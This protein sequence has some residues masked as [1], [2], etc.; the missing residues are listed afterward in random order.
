[1][2]STAIEV[3]ISYSHKDED[4]RQELDAH[5]KMLERQGYI[6]AW[7]DR[8]IVPGAE[9]DHEISTNLE[10]A[11]LILLLV[12]ANC[13]NSDYCWN[14]EIDR[15]IQRHEEADAVVVPIILK[16]VDWAEAPFSKLQAMPK[17]AQPVVTW[18]PRD[19]A[20][21]DITKGLR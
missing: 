7:H 1:M 11:D 12:S 13:L 6:S 4:L 8:K 15:A 20:F 9:W 3:F 17:N 16:P 14:I 5:L 2:A 18:Q 21:A 10:K 19:L